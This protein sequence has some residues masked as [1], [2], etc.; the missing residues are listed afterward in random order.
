MAVATANEAQRLRELL[1]E[2]GKLGGTSC[3]VLNRSQL[4][5]GR[6]GDRLGFLARRLRRGTRLAQRIGDSRRELRAVSR[7]L[8]DLFAGPGGL[9]RGFR[10]AVEIL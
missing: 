3:Q 6:R 2:S 10:D 4:L 7:H 9:G 5:G 8:G 1:G